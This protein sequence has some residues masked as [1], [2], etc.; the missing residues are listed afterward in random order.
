MKITM[1]GTG[2]VGLT[3][4][5][6]FAKLGHDVICVDSDVAKIETLNRG[7]I[8]IYEPGLEEIVRETVQ[9]GR[10]RF[11]TDIGDAVRNSVVAFIAVGTPTRESGEPDLTCVEDVARDI[12]A[13]MNEY[14][15]IVEKSTVPVQTHKWIRTTI[16]RYNRAGTPFDVASNPEFLREGSAVS[17]FLKPDRIVIGV[18]SDRARD[19]LVEAYRPFEAPIVVTDI[20][21]AEL[22][23]HASN[24]FLA[25]KISFANALSVVCEESGADVRQVTGGMG[26]DKRIGPAFLNSGIGYGGFCFPKDLRA[27]IRIAEELG[28]DFRLLREVENVNA[29][30]KRRFVQKIRGVLWNLRD[31]NIGVL[32]LAF[33]PETDDMRF[34]PSID[35]IK[36]L[37][38]RGARVRAYDPQAMDRARKIIPD[39]EFCARAEDVAED[40][41]LLAVLTE[42]PQFRELD[43]AT[44]KT[45]M[46]VPIICDGR[47]LFERPAVERLGFTYI[48]VGR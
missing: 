13:N 12:A 9:A 1:V 43:L 37:T 5:A 7:G 2:Y 3:T 33:K 48:G 22:I 35:I 42:W 47:N 41:D 44:L 32:G 34:A 29:D 38:G 16:E 25:M 6:C 27:F 31:K 18:E 21:S 40:A 11:T 45:R 36:E 4:G 17:D 15:L 19:L 30:M 8:P 23:K 39:I 46:R 14:Q 26:M 24:A 28:Y 20:A 10:L